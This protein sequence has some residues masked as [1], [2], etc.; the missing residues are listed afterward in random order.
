MAADKPS[1]LSGDSLNALMSE[2]RVDPAVAA[3]ITVTHDC[4]NNKDNINYDDDDNDNE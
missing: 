4:N 2:R 1:L 3:H